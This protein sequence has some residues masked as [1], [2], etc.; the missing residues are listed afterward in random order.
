[1]IT[2]LMGLFIVLYAISQVDQA[3]FEQLAQ[4]LMIGFNEGSQASILDGSTEINDGALDA[5]TVDS[6]VPPVTDMSKP[7]DNMALAQAEIE[8]MTAVKDQ[9]TA[10]LA[11]QGLEGSV[12]FDFTNRGLVM[13]LVADD[14]F[15]AANSADLTDPAREVLNAAAVALQP[16]TEDVIVEGNANIIPAG[17]RYA[18]NWELSS[19][20]A[21]QVVRWFIGDGGIDSGRLMAVGYGDTRPLVPGETPEALAANR[22]VDIVVASSASD[23]VRALIPGIIAHDATTPDGNGS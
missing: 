16:R 9:I 10:Q 18:T 15:F 17:G 11:A 1:M 5:T 7:E 12:T 21:T 3:K 2:V 23:A 8:W 6:I 13:S 20:R 14:L 4:S 19:D 22:R